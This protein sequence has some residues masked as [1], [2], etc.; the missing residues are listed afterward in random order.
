MSRT[1]SVLVLGLLSACGAQSSTQDPV[2]GTHAGSGGAPSGL[3]GS[4]G[5]GG[6]AAVAVSGA[7]GVGVLSGGVGGRA[8]ASAGGGQTSSGGAAMVGGLGGLETSGV[9]GATDASAGKANGGGGGA[10]GAACKLAQDCVVPETDPPGC[11]E[12]LCGNGHCSFAARDSDRDRYASSVCVAKDPTVRVNVGKDCD[13]A[14]PA[15][16]PFANELCNGVDDDCDGV[17][18]VQEGS[19]G[20]NPPAPGAHLVCSG[21]TWYA[22]SWH[23]DFQIF[24]AAAL[25]PVGPCTVIHLQLADSHGNVLPISVPN[26]LFKIVKITE[27]NYFTAD[28]DLAVLSGLPSTTRASVLNIFAD[29]GTVSPEMQGP[30]EVINFGF[31]VQAMGVP[32]LLH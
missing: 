12:A 22:T 3:A 28:L 10:V 6:I 31:Y 8:A 9:A 11:A 7:A 16:R 19:A 17:I 30:S 2:A 20:T 32:F 26:T 25:G 13:D 18:D 29:S 4:S 24:G 14:N 1:G 5:I 15:I 23:I 21:G 27:P